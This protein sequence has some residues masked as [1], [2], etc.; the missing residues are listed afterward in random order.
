M[1]PIPH[2]AR[3]NGLPAERWQSLSDLD[4]QL[5]DAMLGLLADAGVAAYALPVEGRLTHLL[6]VPVGDR[7]LDRLFVAGDAAARAREVLDAHLPELEAELEADAAAAAGPA[8]ADLPP[9]LD[10]AWRA[11]VAGYDQ[12]APGAEDRRGPAAPAAATDDLPEDEPGPGRRTLRRAADRPDQPAE[13]RVDPRPPDSGWADIEARLAAQGMPAGPPD[14]RE[15]DDE[16]HFVPPPPPPHPRGD[17]VTRWAWAGVV[18]GPLLLTLATLLG[19]NVAGWPAVLGVVGFLAGFG[20]LVARMG[21]GP[22]VD[23]GPDDGAVV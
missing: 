18:G 13:G 11:I 3:G 21:D 20:T 23:D 8:P 9:D 22:R 12:D 1:T 14:D 2:G 10:E 15:P 4:P 19:W 5:A 6:H 17:A 16:D 7:P